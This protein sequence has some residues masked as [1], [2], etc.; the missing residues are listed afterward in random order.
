MIAILGL[1]LVSLCLWTRVSDLNTL[2]KESSKATH[3]VPGDTMDA[4]SYL[5][6]NLSYNYSKI[7]FSWTFVSVYIWTICL[8]ISLD[9]RSTN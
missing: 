1:P 2:L 5:D 3:T 9:I 7:G 4:L 8:F 6:P